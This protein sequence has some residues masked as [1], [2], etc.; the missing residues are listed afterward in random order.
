MAT[1]ILRHGHNTANDS[2]PVAIF[3]TRKEAEAMRS[4]IECY[5]NQYLELTALSK[6]PVNDR[7]YAQE[8]GMTEKLSCCG[9]ELQRWELLEL[10]AGAYFSTGEC[11]ECWQRN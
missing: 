3:S 2:G 10:D 5:N 1:V 7:H 11:Q 8:L 9:K 6:L 4:K